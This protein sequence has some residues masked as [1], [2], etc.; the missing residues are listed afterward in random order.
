M[1]GAVFAKHVAVAHAQARRAALVLEILG[2]LADDAPGKEAVLL[3]D[4]GVP[5]EQHMR[6]DHATRAQHHMLIDHGV[7]AD[8]DRTGDLGMRMDDGGGMNH[9]RT[10]AFTCKHTG[11]HRRD[12][13]EYLNPAD[14][15]FNA[16]EQRKKMPRENG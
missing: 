3:A 13:E 5:G 8:R 7:R 14:P 9:A 15:R 6:A 1:H 12:T 2:R 16:F 11:W 10:I 4:P